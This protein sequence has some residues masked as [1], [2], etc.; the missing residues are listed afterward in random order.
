MVYRYFQD[1][2]MLQSGE[3]TAE[4]LEFSTVAG[5]LIGRYT[6]QQGDRKREQWLSIPDHAAPEGAAEDVAHDGTSPLDQ[7]IDVDVDADFS[8]RDSGARAGIKRAI[9]A[10]EQILQS[11]DKS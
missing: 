7:K 3:R 11:K 1:M 4:D 8:E 2:M 9:G 5:F 6:Q 10:L